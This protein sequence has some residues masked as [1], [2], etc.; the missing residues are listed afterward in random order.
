MTGIVEKLRD[1]EF[2]GPMQHLRPWDEIDALHAEAAA[3]IE[4]LEAENARLT[5]ERREVVEAYDRALE[6]WAES[7]KRHLAA[8]A[9]RDRLAAQVKALREGLER[10][11]SIAT[12]EGW[13][14][15]RDPKKDAAA[16]HGAR[17]L[18]ATPGGSDE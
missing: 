16:F 5:S 13:S 7:R 11:M 14:T 17:T 4:A 18:L 6:T 2:Q 8:E 10:F 12:A 3:R 1:P 9:D 15:G